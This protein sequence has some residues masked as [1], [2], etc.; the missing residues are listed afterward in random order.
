MSC[1][2]RSSEGAE[3]LL[4]IEASLVPR[5]RDT[6]VTRPGNSQAHSA[7]R[8]VR[9]AS[10]LGTSGAPFSARRCLD[11]LADLFLNGGGE[12]LQGKGGWPDVTVVEVCSV[13]ETERRVSRLELLPALEE[14]DKTRRCAIK[15][16][17]S[18]TCIFGL[19]SE[20]RRMRS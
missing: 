5:M 9:Q 4:D 15:Y 10:E 20:G 2:E 11:K 12:P 13:L 14:A 16:Q 8:A 17:R 19:S 18:P 6:S 7:T 1:H 3:S